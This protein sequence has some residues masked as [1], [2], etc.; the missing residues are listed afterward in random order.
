MFT[1]QAG[2]H[3]VFKHPW[4]QAAKQ[5]LP[6]KIQ[7]WGQNL[8]ILQILGTNNSKTR[9]LTHHHIMPLNLNLFAGQL[10][11]F[12]FETGKRLI[13]ALGI[14]LWKCFNGIVTWSSVKIS[15]YF[16]RHNICAGAAADMHWH[17]QLWSEIKSL[18]IH[19]IGRLSLKDQRQEP[20]LNF[21]TLKDLVFSYLWYCAC[22][23]L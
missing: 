22:K 17:A 7:A 16:R 6:H 8:Q 5:P 4:K 23:W 2:L 21:D 15:T 9:K 14:G 1:K 10:F 13:S 18:N 3:T 11:A 12:Q 20:R 19:L